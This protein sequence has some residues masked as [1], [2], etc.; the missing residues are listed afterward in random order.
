M[1]SNVR[2]ETTSIQSQSIL[3][4][5]PKSLWILWAL[6][7][8][9]CARLLGLIL[10]SKERYRWIP[11]R[12]DAMAS[13]WVTKDQGWWGCQ[14]LHMETKCKFITGT[15]IA[16]PFFMKAPTF[17]LIFATLRNSQMH[18]WPLCASITHL[19][20]NV[21]KAETSRFDAAQKGDAFICRF[22]CPADKILCTSTELH[23]LPIL[24]DTMF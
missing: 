18:P 10:A 1:N 20:H 17:L 15:V 3:H 12:Q 6:P 14:A 5:S 24:S 19:L 9:I 8:V 16:G 23:T 22:S 7:Q 13:D 4:R 2:Q 11:S 21:D